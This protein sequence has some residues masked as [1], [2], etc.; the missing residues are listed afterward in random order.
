MDIT[1][2]PEKKVK[3]LLVG[4]RKCITAQVFDSMEKLDI[5]NAE[6]GVAT[7]LQALLPS[8]PTMAGIAVTIMEGPPRVGGKGIPFGHGD[9]MR[10]MNPN[11]VLVIAAGGS[12]EV[13]FWGSMFNIEAARRGLAGVVIDGS[14]RDAKGIQEAG[15]PVFHRGTNPLGSSGRVDTLSVNQPVVCAGVQVHPAISLSPTLTA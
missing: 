9:L 4:F 11:E 8:L 15:L 7:G 1:S 6:S 10:K 5:P 3:E 2:L 12:C 13:S 14:L